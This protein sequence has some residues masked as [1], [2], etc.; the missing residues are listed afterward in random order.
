MTSALVAERVTVDLVVG[1]PAGLAGAFA[2]CIVAMVDDGAFL[3]AAPLVGR[4]AALVEAWLI[5]PRATCCAMQVGLEV[6][7]DGR[8]W[9]GFTL[10]HFWHLEGWFMSLAQLARDG[11]GATTS[12][13]VW[14]ESSLVLE[15]DDPWLRMHDA[16]WEKLGGDFAWSPVAIPWGPFCEAVCAA[17]EALLALKGEIL[18]TCAARGMTHAR[19]MDLLPGPFDRPDKPDDTEARLAVIRQQLELCS[20]ES[21]LPALRDALGGRRALTPP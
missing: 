4:A 3:L 5:M 20:I 10:D 12:T 11:P 16:R 8:S 14:D 13:F 7:V 9:T 6:G 17:G 1:L 15:R 18:A 19:R 21:S 2:D